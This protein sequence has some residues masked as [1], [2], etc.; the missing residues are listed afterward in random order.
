[1]RMHACRFHPGPGFKEVENLHCVV[2]M[3]GFKD[4]SKELWLLQLPKQVR[5]ERSLQACSAWR[6]S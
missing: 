6:E 2:D 1:M 4:G 5:A 3:E